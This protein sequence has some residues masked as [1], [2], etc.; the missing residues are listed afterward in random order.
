M[1]P[2]I[3]PVPDGRLPGTPPNREWSLAEVR[4]IFRSRGALAGLRHWLIVRGSV[5]LVLFALLYVGNGLLIGW[6]AAYDVTTG[7]VSPGSTAAPWAAWPLSLAGWLAM[8]AVTGAVAGYVLSVAIGGRR[9]QSIDAALA[10][11]DD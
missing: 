10:E 9:Q 2:A 3:P 8:P 11:R 1:Q 7:I 6:R 5:L 4:R